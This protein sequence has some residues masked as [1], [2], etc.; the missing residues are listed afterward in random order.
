M[1]KNGEPHDK[2]EKEPGDKPDVADQMVELFI[3]LDR[4]PARLKTALI[5][6]GGI[7]SQ[8]RSP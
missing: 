7:T 2:K 4:L 1:G 8:V 3:V 6:A 5:L